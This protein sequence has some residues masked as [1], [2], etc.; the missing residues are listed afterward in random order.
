MDT[1]VWPEKRLLVGYKMPK[2]P[3]NIPVNGKIM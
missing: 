3:V 1:G 2:F